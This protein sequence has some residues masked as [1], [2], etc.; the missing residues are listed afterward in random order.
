MT[1]LAY[2]LSFLLIA[3]GSCLILYT[4]AT[5]S[6]VK[7]LCDKFPLRYIAVVQALFGVLFLISASAFTYPWIIRIIGLLAVAEGVLAYTDPN[8]LYSRILN[9]YFTKISDQAQRLFGIIA[10]I[11]GTAMLSWVM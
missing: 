3:I 7:A 4:Q 5:V 1:I 8:G 10:I 9:W 11:L 6:A 2:V